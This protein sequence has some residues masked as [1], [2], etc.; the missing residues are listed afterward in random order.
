MNT[1]CQTMITLCTLMAVL[2]PARADDDVNV[3]VFHETFDSNNGTGGR[4]D[5]YNG[6][7]A[8]SAA[9]YDHT[10]WEGTSVYGGKQCLK[11]GSTSNTGT[12]TTP[13]I[14]PG[15]SHVLLTFSAAGW[16]DQKKNTLTVRATDGVTLTGDTDIAELV[17]EEWNEYS[18]LISMMTATT[19]RLT[20][21]GKRG[22]IDDVSVRA[23]NAVPEP[24][25]PDDC[26][27]WP[28]TTETTATKCI[29]IV[30]ASYTTVRYTTDGSVPTATHGTAATQTTNVNM[31]GTTT[32]KAVALVGDMTSSVVSRTYTQG[33]TT[34]NGLAA[35]KALP[36]GTEAR[37]FLSDSDNARVTY[38]HDGKRMFLRE[39]SEAVCLDFG[40]AA[41]PNPTPRHNQHVAGWIVGRK[42]TVDG[43]TTLEATE[44]TSTNYLAMADAVTEAETRPS[45][46]LAADISSHVGDLVT[47]KEMTVG[48]EASTRNDF[49]LATAQPYDGAIVDMTGVVTATGTIAPTETVTFVVDEN[50]P[51]A[52]PDSDL[53]QATVRLKRTL[54]SD[55]WNTLAVPF[56]ITAM[57]GSIR[58]YDHA[59]GTTMVF[60]NAT[61]IEAGKPYL[62]KPAETVENPVYE[63]VT[64]RSTAPQTVTHGNYSYVAVYEPT[65]LA[66]DQTEL[67]VTTD[68]KLAYPAS[69]S[70]PMKGL[71]AYIKVL[72]G[73]APTLMTDDTTGIIS[74]DNAPRSTLRSTS[75]R[76]Q[77]ENSQLDNTPLYNLNGQRVTKPAR[78]GIYIYNGKK[79]I[80]Q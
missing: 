22:F 26:T 31:E 21:T 58:E 45:D 78:G 1:L 34:V 23:I 18:V 48:T 20:F 61:A 71:R 53:E 3:I 2:Q 19:V 67:F 68:G 69:T 46:I 25:L 62:V 59:D 5:R 60:S 30:P 74:V 10:G 33:S 57:E 9:Q 27:F 8:S 15:T 70:E 51:F 72:T 65:R 4:D 64:L 17:N 43:L 7:I 36:D 37:L 47:V 50:R 16:G 73:E 32:V 54:S 75:G 14:T 39:G 63:G 29:S 12:C 11:I 77:G 79:I 35:L 76:S 42:Q 80:I 66:T 28:A 24:A 55:Y 41:T 52:A 49:A 13:A 40:T 38:V 44:N 56:D 6:Q